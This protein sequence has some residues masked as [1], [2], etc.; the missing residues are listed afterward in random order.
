MSLSSPSIAFTS[1]IATRPSLRPLPLHNSSRRPFPRRPRCPRRPH[2]ATPVMRARSFWVLPTTQPAL[3]AALEANLTDILFTDPTLH[4]QTATLAR[5]TSY[6]ADPATGQFPDGCL[7]PLHTPA[8]V[9]DLIQNAAASPALVIVHPHDWRLIPLE[10]LIAA[11][12]PLS[13]RLFA[14]VPSAAD[15]AAMLDMLEYGVDGCVL[16]A[17]TPTVISP[18]AALRDARA[19]DGIA[20]VGNLI[21]AVVKAVNNAGTGERVCVDTLSLLREDEG[22]LVGSSSQA[23]FLALSEAKEVAYVPSRPFRVNAGAVHSYVLCADGRTRYLSEL[24]AG[25]VVLAVTPKE[26][27][28]VQVREVVVGRAKIETRPML[29]IEVEVEQAH[30]K[31]ANV[32]VQNAETVRIATMKDGHVGMTSVTELQPGDRVVL[33]TD[34]KARHVGMPIDER[35]IEK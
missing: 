31:D 5:F 9:D 33:R 26:N 10:N 21:T 15:A 16:L 8:D 12:Q 4:E 25:H 30:E 2:A 35:L 11:F 29:L 6:L 17:H 34:D 18:F 32:F 13:T 1:S 3:T 14:V 19:L 20:H 7:I 24:T 28:D 22:L 27:G 23:M